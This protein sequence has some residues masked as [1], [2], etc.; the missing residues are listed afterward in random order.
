MVDSVA[1]ASKQGFTAASL[2]CLKVVKKFF[3]CAFITVYFKE[4]RSFEASVV[5]LSV[6]NKIQAQLG[7]AQQLQARC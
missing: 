6:Q 2:S 4:A 5:L 3:V 7:G 1:M